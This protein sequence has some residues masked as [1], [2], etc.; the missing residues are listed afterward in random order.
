MTFAPHS[1]AYVFSFQRI[2]QTIF[3]PHCCSLF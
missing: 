1:V 2:F 3:N